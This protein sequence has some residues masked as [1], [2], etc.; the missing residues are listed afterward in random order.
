M[1]K[2]WRSPLSVGSAITK[3]TELLSVLV[4]LILIPI[5]SALLVTSASSTVE[6]PNSMD[7]DQNLV[8]KTHF[9]KTTHE[10]TLENPAILSYIDTTQNITVEN[11]QTLTISERVYQASWSYQIFPDN[12]TPQNTSETFPDHYS[13]GGW[14]H[15]YPVN[16]E[17]FSVNA[18]EINFFIPCDTGRV[19]DLEYDSTKVLAFEALSVS[20]NVFQGSLVFTESGGST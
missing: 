4:G 14:A 7:I 17:A 13:N 16:E 12:N 15:N 19:I 9:L 5:M 11:D 20:T 8:Y 10:T 6:L 18:F 3:R 1:D 2:K